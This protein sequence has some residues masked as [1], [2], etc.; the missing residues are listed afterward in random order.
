MDL[1]KSPRI[2]HF[3]AKVHKHVGK[4]RTISEMIACVFVALET[5]FT[6]FAVSL[7]VWFVIDLF[8]FIPTEVVEEIE[9]DIE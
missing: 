7:I 8:E 9:R 4:G 5:H 2:A 1:T 3:V 6:I